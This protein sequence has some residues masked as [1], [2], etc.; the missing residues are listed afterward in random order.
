MDYDEDGMAD[1]KLALETLTTQAKELGWKHRNL[2]TK[3]EDQAAYARDEIAKDRHEVSQE[4]RVTCGSMKRTIK[5]VTRN[6][7]QL[8]MFAASKTA[9]ATRDNLSHDCQDL[10]IHFDRLAEW[11]AN[12]N[13]K[14][15]AI[16]RDAIE[17]ET[18]LS[19]WRPDLEDLEIESKALLE[20]IG[21]L[22]EEMQDASRQIVESREE[23]EKELSSRHM[24]ELL[25][26]NDHRHYQKVLLV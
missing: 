5:A 7:K 25:Y 17:T 19:A 4:L 8:S 12:A 3:A 11:A 1:M 22:L 21:D 15:N 23:A 24:Q 13:R 9:L 14:L 16:H 6:Q 18:Q 2:E 20:N 26:Q 10:T